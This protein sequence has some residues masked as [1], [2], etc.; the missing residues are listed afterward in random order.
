MVERIAKTEKI[1]KAKIRSR[2]HPRINA[3][4]TDK[5]N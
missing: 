1:R 2:D 3:D 5:R 4:Y